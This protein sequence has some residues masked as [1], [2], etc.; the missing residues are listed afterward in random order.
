MGIGTVYDLFYPI[1]Y[2]ICSQNSQISSLYPDLDTCAKAGLSQLTNSPNA[3][4]TSSFL[5][6][7]ATVQRSQQLALGMQGTRNT[8]TVLF[9]RNESQSILASSAANDDFLLNNTNNIRQR[10]FSI[11]LS[12]QLSAQSSLN[13]MGSRQQS[14]GTTTG[15]ALKATTMM[16]QASLTSKLGAKTTGGISIRCTEFENSNTPYTEN[17]LIGTLSVI[18]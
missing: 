17:A 6:S 13:L 7:R 14:T 16:Y 10:G 11:N 4:V 18:F 15:N 2:Q 5:A 8:L 3:Q 1:Y 12:H 9:S